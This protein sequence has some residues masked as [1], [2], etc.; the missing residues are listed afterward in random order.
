MRF[1]VK[2]LER[3]NTEHVQRAI[4]H[5]QV[6]TRV[7]GLRS[8]LDIYKKQVNFVASGIQ[9]EPHFFFM[10]LKPFV[11]ALFHLHVTTILSY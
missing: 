5:E 11:Q 9:I 6:A 7:H 4:E 8:Q 2:L 10:Y 3:A 1:Q